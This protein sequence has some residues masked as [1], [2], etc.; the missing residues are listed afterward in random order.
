MSRILTPQQKIERS[1]VTD[2]R[3]DIWNKF[4][5]GY[6]RYDM[7]KPGD[8]IAVCISGGK[9]SMLL[10]KCM[11]H[12]QKYQGM[13]VGLEFIV[14]NPGYSDANRQRIIDNAALMGIP[15]EMFETK[16]FD[17]AYNQKRNP[18]YLCARMRRGWLYKFAQDLGCNKIALGHHFDDVIETILMSMVYGGQIQTMMPKLHSR[19]YAG[20]ELIR[21]LYMVKEADIIR[22]VEQNDL[23]FI[24]CAC[25]LTESYEGLEKKGE[26]SKRQEM[27][28]L[29]AKFRATNPN[30]ENNIFKSVYNV[31]L[32]TVIQ[33]EYKGKKYNFTDTYDDYYPSVQADDA[34]D[35]GIE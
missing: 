10:A 8:K 9:D 31:N 29:I 25:R 23:H 17:I 24:R 35:E 18:C 4:V 5:M 34:D 20:M 28:E 2:F 13:D 16:V 26:V 33:Y 7:I 3:R 14:M 21:P 11:Q 22:W 32:R 6:E 12:L 27:K 1:I 19:N 30:I 15:I